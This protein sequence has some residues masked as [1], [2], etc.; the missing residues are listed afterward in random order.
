MS[1]DQP[2]NERRAFNRVSTDQ[3]CRLI[4]RGDEYSCAV[5]DISEG[6][7]ALE[8]NVQPAV[9]DWVILYFDDMGRVRAQVARQIERG[10]AVAF[11]ITQ[12]KR[13]RVVERLSLLVDNGR[14]QSLPQERLLLELLSAAGGVAIAAPQPASL[15]AR[16]LNEL[17][18]VGLIASVGAEGGRRRYEITGAGKRSALA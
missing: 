6:G 3:M 5:V 17:E 2:P 8:V 10:V 1:I 16:T 15:L 7:A 13:D 11:S 12:I 18:R 14:R 9:G 4:Y